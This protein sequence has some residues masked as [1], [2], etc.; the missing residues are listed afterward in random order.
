MSKAS[1]TLS[2]R[3]SVSDTVHLPTLNQRSSL[4]KMCAGK[5]VNSTAAQ[6]MFRV[7]EETGTLNVQMET[8]ADYYKRELDQKIKRFTALFEPAVIIVVGIVVGFVAVALVTAMY[9][10]YNQVQ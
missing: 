7:G 9:G 5:W 4:R 1:T 8:A 3:R 2:A 10:V 6:Q